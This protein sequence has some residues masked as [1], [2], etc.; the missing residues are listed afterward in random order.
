MLARDDLTDYIL[1]NYGTCM[2][3]SS[4]C[5]HAKDGCL[6]GIWRGR[7]CPHWRPIEGEAFSKLYLVMKQ[8]NR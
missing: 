2:R 4:E 5:Y 6:G 1:D 8:T 7:A 3:G